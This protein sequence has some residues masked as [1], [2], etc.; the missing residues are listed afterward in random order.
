MDD[1]ARIETAARRAGCHDTL[2]A[3]PRGYQTML[4]RIYVDNADRD[5]PGTG[6]V[7]SGG[8]WQRVALARGLL[9]GSCDLLIL[10]E[11]SAGLDAEAEYQVHS[12]LR[13]HRVG[14]TSLL[15][16]HRLNTVRDADSI[17]VLQDGEVVESGDHIGLIAAD[18][19]YAQLFSRQAAGYSDEVDPT[20]GSRVR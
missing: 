3:L 18:G 1:Q 8:Q 15:I 16:S 4:T 6:V 14:R 7:L 11:P 5:D 13:E 12:R 9:R 10:D 20:S 2:A 17:V 19:V